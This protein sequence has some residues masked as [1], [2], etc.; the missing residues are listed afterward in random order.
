MLEKI[1]RLFKK[2]ETFECIVWDGSMMKYL[3][4]TQKEINDINT[5]PKYENWTVTKKSD[6]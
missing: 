1:T 6:C 4:L 3:D 5:L 2:E